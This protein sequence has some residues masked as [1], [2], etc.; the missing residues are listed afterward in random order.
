MFGST[1]VYQQLF[2]KMKYIKR[3]SRSK[4]TDV[5]LDSLLKLTRSNAEANIV[6]VFYQKQHQKS[7]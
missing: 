5:H 1:Y 2:S 6:K 3:K 7:H 4:L